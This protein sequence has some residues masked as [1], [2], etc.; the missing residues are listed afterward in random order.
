MFPLVFSTDNGAISWS[1]SNCSLGQRLFDAI[2]VICIKYEQ[3]LYCG[4]FTNK[5]LYES[6]HFVYNYFTSIIML[7]SRDGI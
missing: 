6:A 1:P 3:C 5:D 7:V 4:I 2:I